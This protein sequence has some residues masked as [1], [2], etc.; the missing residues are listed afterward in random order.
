[1]RRATHACM[2]ARTHATHTGAQSTRVKVYYKT[3]NESLPETSYLFQEGSVTLEK[4]MLEATFPI[5]IINNPY[6]DVEGMHSHANLT[7]RNPYAHVAH[8]RRAQTDASR[9]SRVCVVC[10]T[11]GVIQLAP[12][13]MCTQG[14]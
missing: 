8:A 1:M 11:C 5:K 2:H 12:F 10:C 6:W 4:D 7:C 13:A 9:G 3:H 14:G